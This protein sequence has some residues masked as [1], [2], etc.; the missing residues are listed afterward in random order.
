[1]YDLAKLT[2]KSGKGGNGVVSFRR[3][4]FVPRGGPD[5]GDGG[6]GGDVIVRVKRNLNT[7][8]YLAGIN[9]IVADDG[10]NGSKQNKIGKGA[11][12]KYIDV[13][14]GTIVWNISTDNQK[15][16]LA[17]LTPTDTNPDPEVI[18]VRGGKGGRGNTQFKSSVNQAPKRAEDGKPSM[19]QLIELEVKLIADIGLVGFPSSGKS[20]LI[21]KLAGTKAKTAQYHFTTLSPN[22]GVMRFRDQEIVIADIPGLIEGASKGKGLGDDFL[23]HIERTKVLVHLIDGEKV[24]TEGKEVIAK[25]YKAIRKELEDYSQTL[26]DKPEIV[27]LNKV[28]LLP[29]NFGSFLEKLPKFNNILG[30]SALS[31]IGI[32]ELK[33]EIFKK[34]QAFPT[35]NTLI[36]ATKF[37]PTFT[38][39]S[40]PNRRM[41][42]NRKV[43]RDALEAL[44][45]IEEQKIKD[46]QE[47]TKESLV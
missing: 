28:D 13:P 45:I 39:D 14:A 5:G 6:K 19:E 35:D 42:F 1:M 23:R 10:D 44:A 36:D 25:D 37:V 29:E 31:G 40:L 4:K 41:I 32:D 43:D 18:V 3:E 20:T 9:V 11:E 16:M 24:L 12:D 21:N 38:I 47:D 8:Q 26:L 7:L 15:T 2:V 34:L 17:D 46:Q 33:D 22:L 30:I 27:V